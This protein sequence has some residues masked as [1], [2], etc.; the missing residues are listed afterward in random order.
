MA[1]SWAPK[2]KALPKVASKTTKPKPAIK[3]REKAKKK[4]SSK[5]K[6]AEKVSSKTKAAEKEAQELERRLE[7][8]LS[9]RARLKRK[10]TD[11]PH[12]RSGD[13]ATRV[14]PEYTAEKAYGIWQKL[15]GKVVADTEED[16]EDVRHLKNELETILRAI[17][18]RETHS[19]MN[20]R[21]IVTD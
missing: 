20:K 12:L 14:Y 9:L 4:V 7:D 10:E 16:E 1:P 8:I 6:A 18:D 3:K 5:T 11:V 13:G 19:T 2:R 21:I 17:Y 15:K